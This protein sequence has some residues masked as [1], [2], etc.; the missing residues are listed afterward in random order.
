MYDEGGEVVDFL[1]KFQ[2]NYKYQIYGLK[3]EGFQQY[4]AHSQHP[5]SLI[6]HLNPSLKQ[7]NHIPTFYLYFYPPFPSI[8]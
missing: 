2:Q 3:Q 6:S 7:I 1:Y 5:L 8:T 4:Y